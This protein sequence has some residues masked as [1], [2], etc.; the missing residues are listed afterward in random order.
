M[1]GIIKSR[2]QIL[3]GNTGALYEVSTAPTKSSNFR[4]M[5]VSG[6]KFGGI[7]LIA[8]LMLGLMLALV[9]G[10]LSRKAD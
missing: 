9:L 2:E 5:L 1:S 3:L 4:P 7:G 6:V 10:A 8:G